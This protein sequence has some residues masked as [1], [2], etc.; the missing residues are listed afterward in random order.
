MKPFCISMFAWVWTPLMALMFYM[1]LHSSYIFFVKTL[2]NSGY[3]GVEKPQLLLYIM[4]HTSSLLELCRC[5]VPLPVTAGELAQLQNQQLVATQ[6]P[7]GSIYCALAHPDWV[8]AGKIWCLH[9][10]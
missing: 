6:T 7:A 1:Y 5:V 2:T 10:W 4:F 9:S 3:P 8:F